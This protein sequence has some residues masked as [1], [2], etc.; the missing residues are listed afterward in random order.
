MSQPT[1]QSAMIALR[2]NQSADTLTLESSLPIP[3]TEAGQYLIKVAATSICTGE[4]TWPKPPELNI[5]CPGVDA[6]GTVVSGPANGKFRAG[7]KV[8]YR[9]TYPRPGSA[10][11]YSVAL[12]SELAL[13]PRNISMNE[14]AA[15]PTSALTAWQALFE[16]SGLDLSISEKPSTR[17]AKK[18][19]VNG[20]SGGVGLFITQLANLAGCEVVGTSTNEGLVRSLGAFEVINYKK[21]SIREWLHAHPDIRF[22]LV[23]DLVGRDSLLEAWHAAKEGGTVITFVA[24]AD[25]QFKWVLDRPEGISET[26]HGK[27]YVIQPNGSQLQQITELFEGGKLKAIIDSVYR[28]ESFKE[29]FARAHGGRA[30][31][32]VVVQIEG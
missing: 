1:G 6:A 20:A 19:F 15:V 30:V 28:L 17:Y 7:D 21:T 25:L 12:E 24:P 18:V 22:D 2:H 4:L 11:E 32:K 5:S 23:L 16:Q 8:Y 10:R 14:A 13:C 9:T 29:A 26:V 3:Q 31:G 27:F